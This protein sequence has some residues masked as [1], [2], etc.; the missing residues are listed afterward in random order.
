MTYNSQESLP[1]WATGSITEFHNMCVKF[2]QE[3]MCRTYEYHKSHMVQ[4]QTTRLGG[5]F[6]VQY[7]SKSQDRLKSDKI[8]ENNHIAVNPFGSKP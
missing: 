4:Q 8:I 5:N 7:L 1:H 6:K 2:H 3:S